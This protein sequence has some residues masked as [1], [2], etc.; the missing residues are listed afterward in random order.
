MSARKRGEI[1]QKKGAALNQEIASNPNKALWEKGD[2]TEI[3]AFIRQSREAIVDSLSVAPQLRVLARILCRVQGQVNESWV[4]HFS[5]P[6][7][8][9]P[10]RVDLTM[11]VN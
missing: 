11:Y 5:P 3:A 1:T 7:K 9:S 8:L 4:Y 6:C 2:F 10:A